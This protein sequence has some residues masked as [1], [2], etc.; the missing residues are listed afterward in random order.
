MEKHCAIAL[1]ELERWIKNTNAQ[2]QSNV[3]IGFTNQ[4]I[5]DISN[6]ISKIS[7][8]IRDEYPFYA[9]M[10]PQI[11]SILFPIH[12]YGGITINPAAFGELYII[13]RHLEEEPTN[14][15]FWASMH[16]RIETISKGLFDDGH[17][18]S[19]AEKAIKE[20][21]TRLREKFAELK[22]GVFIP[23]KV[24]DIIGALFSENGSYKF[25]DTSTVSGKDYRRGIQLLFEGTIAA[26]RNPAAHQNLTYTKRE[27]IEQIV[28]ASQLMYVLEK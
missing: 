22:P 15:H 4:N 26:Y 18:T 28:M 7:E 9:K 24:G 12:P 14:I 23:S 8:G 3:P 20:V 11:T 21:E 17:Y 25:C 6:L 13:V 16:P 1:H 10:L 19:S 5:Q 27:A 2:M